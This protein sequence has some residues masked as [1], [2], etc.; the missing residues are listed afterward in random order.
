ML[1]VSPVS[2]LVHFP[3]I[4]SGGNSRLV[5]PHTVSPTGGRP[6]S[7]MSPP[8]RGTTT[9]RASFT[10]CRGNAHTC[11]HAPMR[12]QWQVVA[13]TENLLALAPYCQRLPGEIELD[14]AIGQAFKQMLPTCGRTLIGIQSLDRSQG[15]MPRSVV[16]RTP[17]VRVTISHPPRLRLRKDA[18]CATPAAPGATR[19]IYPVN[20]RCRAT[21]PD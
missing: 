1:K 20:R 7:P 18:A 6:C 17:A 15:R 9:S 2:V 14:A 21:L 4:R 12:F 13:V 5:S 11:S 8:S 16:H 3:S 19:L 10:R